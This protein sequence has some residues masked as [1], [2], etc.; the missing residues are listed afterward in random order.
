MEFALVT[1][2]FLGIGFGLDSAF[3]TRPTFAIGCVVFAFVAQFIRMYYV[4][5]ARMERLEA[6]RLASLRSHETPRTT[7]TSVTNEA[8]GGLPT[9]VM[10]DDPQRGDAHV[11]DASGQRDRVA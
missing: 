7:V 5:T 8:T 9:G 2:V 3:G 11:D 6:E 4:Y 1:L 10:L